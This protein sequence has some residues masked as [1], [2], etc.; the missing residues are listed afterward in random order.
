PRPVTGSASAG[1]STVITNGWPEGTAV[2]ISRVLWEENADLAD[3]AL[4]HPFVRGIGDG[5]L[6]PDRFAR[7]IAQDAFY[8]DCY[9]RAYGFALAYS[10]DRAA[11]RTFAD[12]IAGLRDELRLHEAYARRLGID[13]SS[14]EPVA[15]TRAYTEFLLESAA[16]GDI[17][18]TC[19]AMT[20]CMRLYAHLGRCL[21]GSASSDTYRQWLDRHAD[22]GLEARA[23]ALEHLLDTHASDPHR[24]TYRQA[25]RLELDLFDAAYA[26][27][28]T[29]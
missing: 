14:V 11:V 1:A 28:P 18:R 6:P 3:A 23:A 17:G 27:T 13:L 8:L 5:T 7:F 15:A 29:N 24:A 26:R 12:L 9:A 2:S 16:A 21:A 10:P 22:A 25:M 19:A 4:R 20:P